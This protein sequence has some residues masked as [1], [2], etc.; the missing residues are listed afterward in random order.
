MDEK[1]LMG[2]YSASVAIQQEAID[3]VFEGY[4][5][6]KLDLTKLISHRFSLDDA[7]EAV[8]LASNPQPNSM[9]VVVKA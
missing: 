5:S 9:K 6:S 4:R 8:R 7:A 1:T 3:L 2:S